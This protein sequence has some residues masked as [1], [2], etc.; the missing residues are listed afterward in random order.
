M[1]HKLL[2]ATLLL[3]TF[4]AI[5]FI[6]KSSREQSRA[7]DFPGGMHWLCQSCQHGFSTSREAFADWVAEHPDQKL[8]WDTE[9]FSVTNLA[10]ANKLLKRDYREGFGAPGL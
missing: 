1:K 8:E 10:E 2:I 9:K 7:V 6:A 3:A 5:A 4:A